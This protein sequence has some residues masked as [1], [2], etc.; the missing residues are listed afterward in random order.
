[1]ILFFEAGTMNNMKAINKLNSREIQIGTAG[2]SGSWHEQYKD[3]PYIFIG[4]FPFEF[5]EGDLLIVFSQYGHITD[6]NL[7]RDKKTGKSKGFAFIAY[8]N[9]QSATLAV[10][11]FNGIKLGGRLIRVD[12]VAD[13]KPPKDEEEEARKRKLD[14]GEED[15]GPV[16][17]KM[18]FDDHMRKLE[19]KEK[20]KMKKMKRREKK[21]RRKI[22][23]QL[24]AINTGV[25]FEKLWSEEKKKRKDKRKKKRDKKRAEG[26]EVSE[27]EDSSDE[28]SLHR[29]NNNGNNTQP[30]NVKQEVTVKSEPRD[31]ISPPRREIKQEPKEEHSPPR[32]ER[33][34]DTRR[35]DRSRSRSRDRHSRRRSRSRSRDRRRDRSRSKSR[36][37][38][39]NRRS[40]R[41]RS[42]S[43]DRRDKSRSR[44]RDRRR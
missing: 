34:R 12:H 21:E 16:P 1:V 30:S 25:P 44:S 9:F 31:Q 17:K 37:R 33:A 32:A 35:S 13:Y 14:A 3:S 36:S 6:V 19:K 28:E 26:L 38:S 43:R 5:T 41:S 11:N 23:L 18:K 24:E 27:D 8:E 15:P 29:N 20:K 7:V 39:R 2:S 40:R 22:E 10:D 42:R 4:G